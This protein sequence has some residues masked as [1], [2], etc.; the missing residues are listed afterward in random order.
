MVNIIWS[1]TSSNELER[2]LQTGSLTLTDSSRSL[3]GC[4]KQI[5]WLVGLAWQ[6]NGWT[7]LP[8]VYIHSPSCLWCFIGT[9]SF[10]ALEALQSLYVANPAWLWDIWGRKGTEGGLITPWPFVADSW[11]KPSPESVFTFPPA[12]CVLPPHFVW[13]QCTPWTCAA[14][15]W[16]KPPPVGV[17]KALTLRLWC[18]TLAN[19]AWLWNSILEVR[20]KKGLRAVY[21]TPPPWTWVTEWW[22]LQFS[23][24]GACVLTHLP[25]W[26][27]CTASLRSLAVCPLEL[28]GRLLVEA[29]YWLLS[30][31]LCT[32]TLLFWNQCTPWTCVADWCWLQHSACSSSSWS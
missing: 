10:T 1:L 21:T 18:I 15:S 13:K 3:L 2:Y 26:L 20:I 27:L 7:L 19:P 6:M 14:D 28:C 30:L 31:L 23:P 9:T 5:G 25:S 17:H 29:T 4:F 11:L 32:T 22:W 16:L 24:A 8:L 12:F